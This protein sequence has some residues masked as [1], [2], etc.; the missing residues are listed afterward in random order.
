MMVMVFY[1]LIINRMDSPN[2]LLSILY[3]IVGVVLLSLLV[4][5]IMSLLYAKQEPSTIIYEVS[6][7]YYGPR[8]YPEFGYRYPHWGGLP[9]MKPYKPGPPPP[10]PPA[11]QPPPPQPPAQQPPP[12][13]PPQP[14]A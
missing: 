1:N 11:Q 10:Q 5:G 13:P 2:I 14:P 9:G 12:P 7:P 8:W 4:S 3:L 6:R